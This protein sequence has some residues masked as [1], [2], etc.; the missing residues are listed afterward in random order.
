MGREETGKRA[1]QDIDRSDQ[2][3]NNH[4]TTLRLRLRLT[5]TSTMRQNKTPPSPLNLARRQED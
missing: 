4:F 3:A 1:E 5:S 2:S